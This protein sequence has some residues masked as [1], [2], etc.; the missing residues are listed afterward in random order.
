MFSVNFF[1]FLFIQYI[2]HS[3]QQFNASLCYPIPAGVNYPTLSQYQLAVGCQNLLSYTNEVDLRCCELEF[4]EK[5]NAS[6]PRKHGCMA[7]LSNHIDNDRYE[8]IINWIKR[9]KVDKFEEY[10]IFLGKTAHDNFVDLIKNNTKYEVYKLDCYGKYIFAKY[11]IIFG[12]FLF[13][14]I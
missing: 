2:K 11:Y 10:T 6:A 4:Q 9:G 8:D 5:N 13:L 1:I 7:F 3:S 12:V 14:L